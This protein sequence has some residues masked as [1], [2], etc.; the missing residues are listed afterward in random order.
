MRGRFSEREKIVDAKKT[1]LQK[2]EDTLIRTKREV[3]QK[4]KDM[5]S[6][7][8]PSN[9]NTDGDRLLVRF[10]EAYVFLSHVGSATP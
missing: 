7:S 1:E 5:S 8:T 2:L 10:S 9:T 4:R 6:T 3:E